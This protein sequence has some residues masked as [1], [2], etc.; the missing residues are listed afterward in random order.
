MV[1]PQ[2]RHAVGLVRQ[3]QRPGHRRHRRHR[4]PRQRRRPILGGVQHEQRRELRPNIQISTGTSNSHDSGNGIDY[5]DY[6]GLSFYG[7]MAPPALGAK[8]NTTGNN[9]SG[10]LHQLVIFP[11]AVAVHYYFDPHA[12][13]AGIFSESPLS[14]LP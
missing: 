13:S 9:P 10:T 4:R 6:T 2:S 1:P 7:G 14:V 5:G 12:P 11:D 8:S 3:P